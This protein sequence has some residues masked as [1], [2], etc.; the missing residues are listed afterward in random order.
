MGRQFS[1]YAFPQDLE[2]IEREVFRKNGATL[3]VAEKREGGHHIEAAGSF[4]LALER[5]G[6]ETL[7]L[8]LAP[9]TPLQKLVFSETWLD[10]SRSHLIEVNRCYIKDGQIRAGR[11]WYEPAPLVEGKFVEKPTEFLIWA[12]LVIRSTKKLLVRHR[13]R[14]GKHEYNEW[15]GKIGKQELNAGRVSVIS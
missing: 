14:R 3:L 10:K 12:D 4:P 6:T 2:E 13:F 7:S 5:M 11:F 8:L 9:P 1:Y 15:C